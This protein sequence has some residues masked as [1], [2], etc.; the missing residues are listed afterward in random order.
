[1]QAF[2]SL[3]SF[4]TILFFIFFRLDCWSACIHRSCHLS[5]YV[6]VL[7]NSHSGSILLIGEIEIFDRIYEK[8]SFLGVSRNR[9]KLTR[10]LF[11]ISI[12]NFYT[13]LNLAFY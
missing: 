3:I 12:S 6:R 5:E 1:M 7:S 2:L 13:I 10:V 8:L 4:P 9:S 11:D